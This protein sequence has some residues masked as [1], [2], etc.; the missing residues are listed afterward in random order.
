MK[1]HLSQGEWIQLRRRQCRANLPVEAKLH[2]IGERS[3]RAAE[4]DLHPRIATHIIKTNPRYK[5]RKTKLT[6]GEYAWLA[7]LRA[8]N[9]MP[10]I[11]A[12]TGVSRQTLH[13]QEHD[14]SS[15]SY[16]LALWWIEHHNGRNV[17]DNA[18]NPI[19]VDG[20]DL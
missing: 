8:G 11:A 1:C 3:W 7:R 18:A 16:D 2:G 15:S 6:Y 9:T 17:F 14:L 5:P 13:K 12:L 20:P 19:P 10:E 4:M